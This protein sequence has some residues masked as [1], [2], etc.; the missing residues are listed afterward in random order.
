MDHSDH[1]KMDTHKNKRAR[2]LLP[3]ASSH[4]ANKHVE[5]YSYQPQ[6]VYGDVLTFFEDVDET[7]VHLLEEELSRKQVKV[8]I[9]VRV[10]MS[11]ENVA[12]GEI[13]SAS[14][15]FRSKA[16]TVLAP[17]DIAHVLESAYGAI[18]KK[19]DEWVSEG[20]GW[21]IAKIVQIVVE[22][23]EYTPLRARS[24]FQLPKYLESKKAIVNVQNQDDQCLKL[25]SVPYVVVYLIMNLHKVFSMLCYCLRQN[26]II[27]IT[28]I[29]TPV[30]GPCYQP[31][32][33]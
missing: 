29:Y 7:L 2:V 24:Y 5:E 14:P 16:A 22:F 15:Y 28:C 6:K 1:M 13:Q 12:S 3:F 21:S 20:S 27:I 31:S 10:G 33:Q 18:E 11:K 25:V 23:A 8:I 17:E 30:G 32:T 4:F 19:V 26:L 9:T